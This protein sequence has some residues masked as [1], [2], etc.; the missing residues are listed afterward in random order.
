MTA[1]APDFRTASVTDH[2]DIEPTKT[3]YTAGIDA[4][5]DLFRQADE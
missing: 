1:Q 4:A 2:S 5:R 3:T